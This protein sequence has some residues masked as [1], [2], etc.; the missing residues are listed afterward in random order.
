MTAPRQGLRT[1]LW[2]S[3]TY[4]AEGLPYM[5]VRFLSSV[6]FTDIGVREAYLGFLNFLGIPWNLKFLWAPLLDIFGT[7]RGWMLRIQLAITLAVLVLAGLAGLHSANGIPHITSAMAFLFVGLAFVAA[8]NDIA[9]DAYYLEGLTDPSAQAAYSGLRVLA[10]RIAIIYARSVL[11]GIAGI[12][13]WFYGFGA[14]AATMLVLFCLHQAFSPRFEAERE[15]R[16]IGFREI[17]KNFVDSFLSYLERE[18]IA[19]IL[20][21]V[22]SYKLGDEILFSMNT[23][24]LMRELGVAKTQLAWLAGFVG[25]FA[26]IAGT[27]LGAW[28]IK[29]AGLKGSIWPITLLMNVNILAYIILSEGRPSAATLGGISLIAVIHAYENLAGGL[30]TAALMVYLMRLCSPTYKAAHFAIGTAIMSLG[31]TIVGGFGGI[32]VEKIGYTNLFVLG[33]VAAVPSILLLYWVPL[34]EKGAG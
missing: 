24:F 10:Y 31:S 17:R 5:I 20:C 11:V 7:K 26:T 33:F 29:K 30:G 13:N 4:F 15:K 22:A 23:P 27:L 8:T 16:T 25:S 9:I 12:A 18:R 21:F 32:L 19:V 3:S 1:S 6:Y 14:G 28:W 34:D 2:V